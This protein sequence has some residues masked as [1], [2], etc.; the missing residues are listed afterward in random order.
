MIIAIYQIPFV[1]ISFSNNDTKL[2]ILRI[3]QNIF[4]LKVLEGYYYELLIEVF[5]LAFF[6]IQAKVSRYLNKL[7]NQ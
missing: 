1:I 2:K 3:G 7:I 5:I 4:G 6:Y